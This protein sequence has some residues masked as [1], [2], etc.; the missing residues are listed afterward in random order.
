MSVEVNQ[1]FADFLFGCFAEYRASLPAG[2]AI[3]GKLWR[4]KV[5]EW[6][7]RWHEAKDAKAPRK[8]RRTMTDEEWLAELRTDPTMVGLDFDKELA[9]CRFWCKGRQFIVSWQR[10]TEPLNVERK[11]SLAS[12]KPESF[13][14]TPV[15]KLKKQRAYSNGG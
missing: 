10:V 15:M 12:R 2:T 3:Q 5:A 13:P 6:H 7:E 8:K 9:K 1:P 14:R 11:S 4:E